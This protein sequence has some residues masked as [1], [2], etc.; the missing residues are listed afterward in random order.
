MTVAGTTYTLAQAASF[1]DPETLDLDSTIASLKSRQEHFGPDDLRPC[2]RLLYSYIA[3]ASVSFR[4][5]QIKNFYQADIN[6]ELIADLAED[7]DPN[8]SRILSGLRTQ[9]SIFPVPDPV[10]ATQ[11]D[12]EETA[13]LQRQV[14][15]IK[16][17]RSAIFQESTK[18]APELP[19]VTL[20]ELSPRTNRY[21]TTFQSRYKH[22]QFMQ[23]PLGSSIK[24]S[25]LAIARG[26]THCSSQLVAVAHPDVSF[27]GNFIR[28]GVEG[29]AEN[30]GQY[31]AIVRGMWLADNRGILFSEIVGARSGIPSTENLRSVYGGAI[32][33]LHLLSLGLYE[34]SYLRQ[35]LE[36]LATMT[37]ESAMIDSIIKEW[38]LERVNL[39]QR[40][41]G[42]IVLNSNHP[43]S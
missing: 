13:F 8:L 4:S 2:Y 16:A 23:I 32:T 24:E 22:L 38:S 25:L 18:P 7:R 15:A 26:L 9:Q 36:G 20:I 37:D 27:D 33:P 1:D 42:L 41:A 3:R 14:D 6:R 19:P 34:V 43:I 11:S 12:A 29:L 30:L 21:P 5:L 31:A 17:K 28:D 10:Q 35:L 40:Q 39:K